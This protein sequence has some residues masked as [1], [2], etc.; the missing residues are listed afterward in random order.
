MA[1]RSSTMALHQIG[2][3]HCLTADL[4]VVQSSEDGYGTAMSPVDTEHAAGITTRLEHGTL[5]LLCKEEYAK[6]TSIQPV[7]LPIINPS[8]TR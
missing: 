5:A 8:A 1:G 2:R 3:D 4:D 6:A 7:T